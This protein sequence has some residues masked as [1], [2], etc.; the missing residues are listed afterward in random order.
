MDFYTYKTIEYSQNASSDSLQDRMAKLHA[1]AVQEKEQIF[2][3]A[4]DTHFQAAASMMPMMEF[5]GS[6]RQLQGTI[7][8]HCD[9]LA[10]TRDER[11]R[12]RALTPENFLNELLCKEQDG[13][14]G[15]VDKVAEDYSY[16]VE[17]LTKLE[18][19]KGIYSKVNSLLGKRDEKIEET[20]SAL[21]LANE[22]LTI[23]MQSAETWSKMPYEDKAEYILSRFEQEGSMSFAE[24]DLFKFANASYQASQAPQYSQVVGSIEDF[25]EQ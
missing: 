21:D 2:Q 20:A 19:N 8:A 11:D 9:V 13:I 10:S 18:A 17:K 3:S 25:I 14:N 6:H 15:F 1:A 24:E 22:Q 16:K 4:I 5:H 12:L 7:S 23:G